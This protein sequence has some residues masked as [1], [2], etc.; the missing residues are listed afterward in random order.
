MYFSSLQKTF[1]SIVF[2]RYV[3]DNESPTKRFEKLIWI[4][5]TR[6]R[7]RTPVSWCVTATRGRT[8]V[9]RKH[10]LPIR[11]MR[12]ARTRLALTL[13]TM[14]LLKSLTYAQSAW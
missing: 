8:I 2:A 11:D 6:A 13:S 1:R 10:V 4:S 3:S 5:W 7:C 14:T 9:L 12:F